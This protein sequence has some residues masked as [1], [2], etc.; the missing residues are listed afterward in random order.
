[1]EASRTR[2]CSSTEQ[3]GDGGHCR[4]DG[5]TEVAEGRLMKQEG[6]GGRRRTDGGV[7]VAVGQI[8]GT[9]GRWRS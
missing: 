1:M 8:N 6:G 5:G 2:W 3:E 4:A 9:E 7:E